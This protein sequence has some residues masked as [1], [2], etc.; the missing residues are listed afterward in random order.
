MNQQAAEVTAQSHGRTVQAIES[1]SPSQ[2]EAIR[3]IPAHDQATHVSVMER[4]PVE[5]F[6]DPVHFALEQSSIFKQFGMPVALSVQLPENNMFLALEAYGL[7]ILLSRDGGGEVRAFL[8]AC[9]HKGSK[10]VERTDAFKAARV[11]C[12]YHAWT[13][14]L[15]GRLVGVPRQEVFAGL[16]KEDHGLAPLA[17]REAGGLI[18]VMLDA[19]APPDFSKLND[20]L[21]ADFEALNLPRLHLYGHKTFH[22]D[23]NWKLVIEPFLEGYHVQRLHAATVGP[24]FADVPTV[25]SQLGDHIRQVSGKANFEPSMLDAPGESIHKTVT[26]TYVAFP[27][28]VVV[29]SPYYVSVMIIKPGAAGKSTVEYFMLTRDP[30]DNDK[31]R[32]LFGKSYEMIVNVF[33]N[34]DFRAACISQVGL[35]S[36]AIKELIYGGLETQIPVFYRILERHFDKG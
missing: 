14:S 3:R 17:S 6:V 22:L 19:A 24:L 34:E 1:L 15:D 21:L 9:Q 27:N 7:P 13:F 36:G 11:S 12:P 33:G 31:A 26:I 32:E 29:T 28:V 23:A 25:P 30:A 16:C 8:N 2:I 4:R 18:W 5:I 35:A 20:E 10:V